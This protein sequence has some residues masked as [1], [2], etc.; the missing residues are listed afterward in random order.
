[1]APTIF[2]PYP[3]HRQDWRVFATYMSAN[4]PSVRVKSPAKVERLATDLS[5]T[6]S[7]ALRESRPSLKACKQSTA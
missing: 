5:A 3:K 6:M 1:M 7:T 4:S 2:L